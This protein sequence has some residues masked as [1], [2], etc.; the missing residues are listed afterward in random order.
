MLRWFR[1]K[2]MKDRDLEAL[3]NEC[4]I[5]LEEYDENPFF[6]PC[7][8]RLHEVCYAELWRTKHKECPLCRYPFFAKQK[9]REL[10]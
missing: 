3:E 4:C 7:G 9:N 1:C 10:L 8:H 5:C 2:P 6:L